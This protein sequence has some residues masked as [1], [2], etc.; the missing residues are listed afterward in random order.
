MDKMIVVGV[1]WVMSWNWGT[2]AN[3]S[4][5]DVITGMARI[6]DFLAGESGIVAR[7]CGRFALFVVQFAY[8]NMIL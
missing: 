5:T 2:G 4:E 7:Y 1:T 6:P 3:Q 8:N